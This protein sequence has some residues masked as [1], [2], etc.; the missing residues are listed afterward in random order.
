MVSCELSR[1]LLY[2]NRYNNAELGPSSFSQNYKFFL[3]KSCTW[4]AS[5]LRAPFSNIAKIDPSGPPTLMLRAQ[6]FADVWLLGWFRT[7]A[8]LRRYGRRGSFYLHLSNRCAPNSV[9]SLRIFRTAEC[10]HK[11]SAILR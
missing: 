5:F 7:V 11:K 4:G 3:S 1:H 10:T 9:G 2:S 8:D 6:L